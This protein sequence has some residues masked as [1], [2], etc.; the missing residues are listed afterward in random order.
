MFPLRFCLRL[1]VPA[2]RF[3]IRELAVDQSSKYDTSV[4]ELKHLGPTHNP[5]GF[6]RAKFTRAAAGRFT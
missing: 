1:V 5:S 2:N 6:P 4:V 3:A